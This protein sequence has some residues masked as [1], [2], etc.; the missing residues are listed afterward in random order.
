VTIAEWVK[1]EAAEVSG[2]QTSVWIS[3]DHWEMLRLLCEKLICNV[4]DAADDLLECAIEESCT[5]A[6]IE[7]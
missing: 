6:G 2:V 1:K 3:P 4:S 5:K 7:I